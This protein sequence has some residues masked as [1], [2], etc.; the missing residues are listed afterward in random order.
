MDKRCSRCKKYKSLDS[1]HKDKHS[2]DNRTNWCKV[3]TKT[4]QDSRK[5]ERKKYAADYYKKNRDRILKKEKEY[6]LKHPEKYRQKQK[7]SYYRNR[8]KRLAKM[9]ERRDANPQEYNEAKRISVF[10]NGRKDSPYAVGYLKGDGCCLYCGEINVFMLEN[11]HVWGVKNDPDFT[12]T[13]CANHHK[14]FRR[15]PKMMENW[16]EQ[17][18]A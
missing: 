3:C 8:D 15:F 1:F 4:Y 9:K 11:H 12:I 5:D 13:L 6:R 16:G 10:L 7:E 2:R 17:I 14:P 18:L